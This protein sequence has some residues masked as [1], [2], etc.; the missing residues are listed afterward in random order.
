VL[1]SFQWS[2]GPPWERMEDSSP[3]KRSAG[4]E[5]EAVFAAERLARRQDLREYLERSCLRRADP[6]ARLDASVLGDDAIPGKA[7]A[8]RLAQ[9]LSIEHELDA[10]ERQLLDRME[11]RFTAPG[12]EFE[13]IRSLLRK[14]LVLPCGADGHVGESVV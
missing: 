14:R 8:T 6:I 9:A 12:A 3:P 13:A 4:S 10:A 7:K 5:I 2:Y 1:I 11:G